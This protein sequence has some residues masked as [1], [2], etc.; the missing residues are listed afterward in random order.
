MTDF[1]SPL[2]TGGDLP[3]AGLSWLLDSFATPFLKAIGGKWQ[4]SRERARWDDALRSYG[5]SILRHYGRLR[6]LGKTEDVPL[7]EVF[8]DVYILDQISARRRFDIRELME[9]PTKRFDLPQYDSERRNGMGLVNQG[10]SLYIL[11]KPG[12]GK[13]TFLKNVAVRAIA[14]R[15]G[16]PTKKR[17]PLFVPLHEWANS[18]HDELLPFLVEQ[19]DVHHFPDAQGFLAH[20][21]DAGNA[22]VLF[23][24][25]DEVRQ[26]REQRAETAR[27]L[28]NFT[29]KYDKNQFLITCRVAASEYAFP[30]LRDVEVADF[31]REQ[32]LQYAQKWFGDA[33]KKYERFA[34]D[35]KKPEN[36]GLAEL[37]N[38]PLLLSLLCLYYDD[39]QA[40]PARRAELYEDAL[41]ALLRKWDGNR[42]IQ[43]DEIYAGLSPKRKQQMFAHIAT[44]AF[45]SGQLYWTTRQLADAIAAYLSHL[46]GTPDA[47]DIDGQAVL[48]AIEAQHGVFVERAHNIHSFSHL[49]FQEYFTARYIAEN[50]ARGTTTRLIREHLTDQRWREVFLLTASLLDSGDD[51]VAEMCRT[52]DRLVGDGW[53]AETLLWAES[54]VQAI[55][56]QDAEQRYAALR[57]AYISISR[58]LSNDV[59]RNQFRA[60]DRSRAGALARSLDRAGSLARS[61][62]RELKRKTS[63]PLAGDI[64]L[65]RAIS[66]DIAEAFSLSLD[67]SQEIAIRLSLKIARDREI[68]LALARDLARA[69]DRD[70]SLSLAHYFADALHR[71]VGVDYAL[72]Y[73]WAIADILALVAFL[74][75]ERSLFMDDFDQTVGFC[76]EQGATDVAS[77]LSN[78]PLP[79]SNRDDARWRALADSLWLVLKEQ[80][81]FLPPREI[82]QEEENRIDHYFY[83][84]ELLVRCLDLAYVTN[85]KEILDGLLRP[86]SPPDAARP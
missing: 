42:S 63:R 85:R 48:A 21:L 25:L 83:A 72:Y 73:G 59:A 6:V 17:L 4:D 36:A 31:T 9:Q 14:N 52:I 62:D 39:A 84:N 24:G 53:L 46:P 70:R 80:R 7:G 81:S 74:R 27:A 16:S 33:G 47:D 65:A 50:E 71:E 67:R 2:W 49:S 29:V 55:G 1:T 75:D 5:Q 57:L 19:L 26:E 77:E 69:L 38:I 35:L 56:R 34:A 28:R 32:V 10:A 44:P 11:G 58:S 79:Q 30:G 40:F 12:A 8:T 23:D 15:L 45:E 37:C 43:R 60:L 20:L 86:P 18:A 51:F 13:T 64:A 41:D 82:S 76:R 68:D 61:L 22:L 3:A 66:R 78:I 54:K